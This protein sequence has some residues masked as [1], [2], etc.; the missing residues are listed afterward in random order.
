MKN[1]RYWVIVEETTTQSRLNLVWHEQSSP[2][3]FKVNAIHVASLLKSSIP[4]CPF[5]LC[6]QPIQFILLQEMK[7]RLWYKSFRIL[8]TIKHSHNISYFIPLHKR[9]KKEMELT[10]VQTLVYFQAQLVMTPWYYL[11]M[12]LKQ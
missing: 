11:L 5:Y 2:L 6:R 12:H 3:L 7:A 10:H 8:N 9:Q 1:N 4:V